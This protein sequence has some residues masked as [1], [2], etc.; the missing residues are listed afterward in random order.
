MQRAEK[1]KTA[2][3]ENTKAIA[4]ILEEAQDAFNSRSTAK[5]EC[6]EFLTIFNESR[7]NKESFFSCSQRLTDLSKTIRAKQIQVIGRLNAEDITPQLRRLEKA[8]NIDFTEIPPRTWFY[9]GLI[10]KSP[11]FKQHLKPYKIN[12]EIKQEWLN[13]FA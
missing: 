2:T 9:R 1:S 6:E 8:H 4:Y 5:I 11:E 7:N 10:L 3:H 13:S 12:S